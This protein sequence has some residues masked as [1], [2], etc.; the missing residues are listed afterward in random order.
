[1]ALNLSMRTAL[2]LSNEL[3]D[4]GEEEEDDGAVGIGVGTLRVGTIE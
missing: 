1:M 4:W 3:L 2:I